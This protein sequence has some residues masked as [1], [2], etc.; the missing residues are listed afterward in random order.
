MGAPGAR[1]FFAFITALEHSFIA[2][3]V[4]RTVRVGTAALRE[5]GRA[6]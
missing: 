4:R 2:V 3:F 5:G 1:E 6:C